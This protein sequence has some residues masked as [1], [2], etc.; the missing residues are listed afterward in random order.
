MC[1]GVGKVR[2]DVRGVE[3]YGRVS[4]PVLGTAG[5]V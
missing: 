5:S 2:K 3:K 4:G 1:T